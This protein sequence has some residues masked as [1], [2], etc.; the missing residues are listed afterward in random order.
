MKECPNCGAM[1][2]EGNFTCSSCGV[3]FNVYQE[4]NEENAG[5]SEAVAN[6]HPS[7]G[8]E[9]QA[10]PK[11]NAYNKNAIIA[12]AFS[13]IAIFIFWWLSIAG[14]SL[15]VKSL[16]EMKDSGEKGKALAIAG[17]VVGFIDLALYYFGEYLIK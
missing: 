11:A 8:S 3:N 4:N 2:P 13:V 6:E 10:K 12:L 14:I 17:I 16:K 9:N 7:E 15:G 5:Y 1:N